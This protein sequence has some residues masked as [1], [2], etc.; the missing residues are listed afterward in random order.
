MYGKSEKRT[1]RILGLAY[2]LF[3][4]LLLAGVVY[5]LFAAPFEKWAQ[6]VFN[7]VNAQDIPVVHDVTEIV[8]DENTVESFDSASVQAESYQTPA[9]VARMEAQYLAV[10]ADQSEDGDVLEDDFSASGTTDRVQNAAIRNATATKCPDFEALL[11]LGADLHVPRSN[12]PLVL[13]YHTHTSESYL[14]SDNGSFWNAYDTHTDEADRNM[15]RIGDA[16]KTVLEN[17]G[18]GVIHDT[19]VY[20]ADYNGAYARSRDGIEKIL[21][22]NPSVQIVLDVH[23][24]AFYYSDTERGKPVTVIDGRKAA[25]AMIISGAEE[26]QIADFSDWEYNLRFALEL[27]NTASEMYETLM[28][29]LYFCQRKYN[30][31][32]CKNALLLEIGTDANTLDEA[33]YSATLCANALVKVI[34]NHK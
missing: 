27:Q 25:Q 34:E 14:L 22:E 16:M 26:G 21:A 4:V 1:Q 20:D 5:A 12:E 3:T 15:I 31:D 23:R 32:I 18:I 13:I 11:M 17:A 7:A 8:A 2:Y 24:D 19:S 28:R 30:M 33:L 6:V 29:P 9:D 10:F